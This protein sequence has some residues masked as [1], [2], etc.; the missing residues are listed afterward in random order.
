MGFSVV[1]LST[2]QRQTRQKGQKVGKN[3]SCHTCLFG[4]VVL[5][6]YMFGKEP[7]LEKEDAK[8]QLLFK[9]NTVVIGF[10]LNKSFRESWFVITSKD[11]LRNRTGSL[12]FLEMVE[13]PDLRNL[14]NSIC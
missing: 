11:M 14:F 6:H 13:R 8:K 3:T 7:S 9:V 5:P 10:C 1:M 12:I 4:F 2:Y